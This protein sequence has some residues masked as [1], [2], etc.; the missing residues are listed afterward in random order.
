M[1]VTINL[2]LI[3][4][5]VVF[6]GVFATLTFSLRDFSRGK[7]EMALS[8][9]GKE[10]WLEPTIVH[11]SELAFLTASIRLI[12]N[13]LI[14]LCSLH[15]V[16]DRGWD[17]W[18]E[19][20]IAAGGSAIVTI[21]SSVTIPHA[22]AYNAG[23]SIIAMCARPLHG[24]RTIFAPLSKILHITDS[25]IKRATSK[26][27]STA[28][29][30]AEN[31]LQSEI[32]AVVEEGEK[33]GVVNE[34]EREM[35]ES[36]IQFRDTSVAQ[37]MT[38]RPDMIALSIDSSLEK[39]RGLMEESGHS[40]IPLYEGSIDHVV[41]VLYARDLLKFVGESA[42][43]FDARNVM[44][45]PVFIPDSKPLRDLLQDFRLQKVHIAIVLDEYGG[46]AGLVTIED[47][48]EEL[49]GEIS[50]EHEPIEPAIFHRLD[51]LTAEVDA[52]LHIDEL[53]RL[54]GTHLPEEADYDTLA[55]FI[56]THL[57]SIP[58]V[59]TEFEHDGAKFHILEAEPQR[60][61]RV[62]IQLLPIPAS[63]E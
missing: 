21:F 37:V 45:P 32:M 56:T 15:L 3:I 34:V 46:T 51:Q 36:I 54:M 25:V 27:E 2:I 7:L 20:L 57:G 28:Q 42:D 47:V 58:A 62:R 18:Q 38:T 12:F 5:A 55:G 44:R 52:K 60:V 24:L 17:Y 23:E 14:L 59:D 1:S 9:R 10:S 43:Q 49:V 53:N 41:G 40:R 50:D 35:I 29:E 19:Y 33:T 4:A 31:D 13:I 8:N 16:R 11:S 61:L 26:P 48:L 63:S 22:L 39:I 6:S 30:H